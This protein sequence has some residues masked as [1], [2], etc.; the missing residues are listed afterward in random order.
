VEYTTGTPP[1]NR[2]PV[3]DAGPDQTITLP[4]TASLDGTATDDGPI[5]TQW[6]QV[7]GPGSVSFANAAAVDTPATFGTAGTYVLQLSASDGQLTASDTVQV[8]EY[9]EAPQSM[10]WE[11]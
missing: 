5:T 2:A 4:S 7:S 6:S 8:V 11:W 1:P 9:T 10:E 3:V